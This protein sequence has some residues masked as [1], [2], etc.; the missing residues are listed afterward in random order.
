MADKQKSLIDHD[1][2]LEMSKPFA[3]GEAAETAVNA[4]FEE[5]YE[6]R[7][8]Y[9]LADIHIVGRIPVA[10]GL[11]HCAMHFGDLNLAEA[12]AAWAFGYEQ[13]RRQQRIAEIYNGSIQAITHKNRKQRT[14]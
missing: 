3:S 5:V 8:K 6:L 10:D 13:S 1:K 11:I 9:K 14:D 7:N 4:F 2:Y 12:M